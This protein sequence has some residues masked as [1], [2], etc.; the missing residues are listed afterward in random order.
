MSHTHS[1]RDSLNL[2]LNMQSYFYLRFNAGSGS[3]FGTCLSDSLQNSI[4]LNCNLKLYNPEQNTTK[5]RK[6]YKGKYN[7][8]NI[9]ECEKCR[10]KVEMCNIQ[11][12]RNEMLREAVSKRRKS[13]VICMRCNVRS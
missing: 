9:N 5:K 2:T 8:I 6:H 12:R 7:K 11:Y 1:Q 10:G 13:T 4:L 3:P